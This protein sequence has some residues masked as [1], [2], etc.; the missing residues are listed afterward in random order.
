LTSPNH[1]QERFDLTSKRGVVRTFDRSGL[2]DRNIDVASIDFRELKRRPRL[3]FQVFR[4]VSQPPSSHAPADNQ[5]KQ[6]NLYKTPR[7]MT[8]PGNFN[9]REFNLLG[10]D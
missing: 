1:S 6:P 2:D 7:R 10:L 3:T 9:P 5:Q 4:Q 8:R